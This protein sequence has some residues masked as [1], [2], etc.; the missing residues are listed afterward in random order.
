MKIKKGLSILVASC[1]VLGNSVW[2]YA[3]EVN[4]QGYTQSE[5]YQIIATE[6]AEILNSAQSSVSTM[7]LGSVNPI[8]ISDI[9]P[10]SNPA[11][12]NWLTREV[13]KQVGKIDVSQLTQ[14]DFN[15]V[16]V[17]YLINGN[18]QNIPKEVGNLYYLSVLCLSD[19][20]IK[21]LPFELG[22]LSELL[23]LD[24][25]QNQIEKISFKFDNLSKL[26]SLILSS[27]KIE[28]IPSEIRNITELKSLSFSYNNIDIMPAWIGNLVNLNYL[29]L[30]RNRIGSI[31]SEIYNLHNLKQLYLDNQRVEL[32]VKYISRN[33]EFSIT[34]P[35]SISGSPIEVTNISNGG[36]YNSNNNSISWIASD[37]VRD[38]SFSF[39]QQISVGNV[40]EIF[41]GTA[42]L[43]TE[44]EVPLALAFSDSSV[45]NYVY[46]DQMLN[47][48]IV[49][50]GTGNYYA[51]DTQIDYDPELLEFKGYSVKNGLKDYYVSSE[52]N[53]LRY[54]IASQGKENPIN[55]SVSDVI[56]LSFA[57]KQVGITNITIKRGQVANLEQE[58]NI[59]NLENLSVKI[60]SPLTAPN[61]V[62]RDGK[63]TLIDL[64]IDGYY[65]GMN[66][67]DTDTTKY[68]TDIIPDGRIDDADLQEIVKYI[69]GETE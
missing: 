49:L 2:G 36:T 52:N 9:N 44:L 65:Y 68:D 59:G 4:Q 69:L 28:R 54:M 6:R 21:E 47:V 56:Y 66:A 10:Y 43:P 30:S 62:N 32:P 27:N 58:I 45:N 8:G 38:E 5:E 17:I 31:P 46:T 15:R 12:D 22:N 20:Q 14:E 18:I 24:I 41:S 25:S 51:L 53:S 39:S 64:A 50:K 3:E 26:Q 1:M 67:I 19:N 13:A 55:S 40:T 63:F 23:S 61:D 7:S 57:P 11:S 37:S 34:N 35:I 33:N 60:E 48:A 16:K 29:G 42:I